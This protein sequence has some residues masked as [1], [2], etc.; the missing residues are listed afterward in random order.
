MAQ[1]I[2]TEKADWSL[3][4]HREK[5]VWWLLWVRAPLL[6][7]SLCR[8]GWE[9]SGKPLADSEQILRDFLLVGLHIGPGTPQELVS[10]RVVVR[11]LLVLQVPFLHPHVGQQCP[12]LPKDA[13]LTPDT[14]S[15]C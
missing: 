14:H 9:G 10:I 13:L 15:T 2:T 1:A 7:H 3:F 6:P 8:W 12:V 11:H 5:D 4:S